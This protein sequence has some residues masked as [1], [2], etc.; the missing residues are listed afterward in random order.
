M[1]NNINKKFA[2]A[3][4]KEL[5]QLADLEASDIFNVPL[6]WDPS[7]LLNLA[8]CDLRD[9]KFGECEGVFFLRFVERCNTF[10]TLFSRGKGHALLKSVAVQKKLPLQIPQVYAQQR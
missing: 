2:A 10:A 6:C 9:G 7:H 8:V 4:H 1:V 5:G 3:I